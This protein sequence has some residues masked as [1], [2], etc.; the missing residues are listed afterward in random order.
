LSPPSNRIALEAL[1]ARLELLAVFDQE[2]EP[3]SVDVVGDRFAVGERDDRVARSTPRILA[4]GDAV[5][6]RGGPTARGGTAI[7]GR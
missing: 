5:T 6:P 7:L 1:G 4:E 3:W 2:A